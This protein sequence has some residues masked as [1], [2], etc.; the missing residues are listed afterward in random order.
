VS[1]STLRQG[2]VYTETVVFSPPQ[3]YA[4]DAPYQIAIIDRPG[5]IRST[6]R[7]VGREPHE[8]AAIGDTVVFAEEKD[9]VEY[10]RKQE[11]P[12]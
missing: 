12:A 6:V 8:R 9:G 10:Y 5:G 11:K 3:Q 7:I 1:D 2:V 4:A